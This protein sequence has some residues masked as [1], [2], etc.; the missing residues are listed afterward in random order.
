MHKN[1]KL[2]NSFK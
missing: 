1:I 2:H